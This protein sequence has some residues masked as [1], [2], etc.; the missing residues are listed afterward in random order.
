MRYLQLKS[1]LT[2][3]F[4]SMRAFLCI[5]SLFLLSNIATTAQTEKQYAIRTIAFYNVENLY[6]YE[7][8]PLTWDNDW[9]PNGKNNWTKENYKD[10]LSKLAKVISE[11]GSDVTGTTP[12]IIGLAE[13]ENRRVLEDLISQP[14]L[15]NHNYGIIHYDSPDRRGID[16]ALI[17]K[18][19]WF[20]P[21]FQKPYELI[22][23]NVLNLEKRKYTRDQLLVSGFLDNEEIH[24]IV[25][26]WPSRFGGAK[27]SQSSRAKAARLNRKIIDS[28]FSENPYAK[29]ITMG[30]F[31][32]N[33]TDESLHKVLNAKIDRKKLTMKGLYN[34]MGKMHKK[35]LPAPRWCRGPRRARSRIHN[36][37]HRPMRRIAPARTSR[38]RAHWSP[39]RRRRRPAPRRVHRCG[40]D[41]RGGRPRRT[42]SAPAGR[43]QGCRSPRLAAGVRTAPVQSCS[44]TSGIEAESAARQSSSRCA[45]AGSDSARIPAAIKPALAAPAAPMAMVA[46]G[47]PLGICTME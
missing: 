47:N 31:N 8:D 39:A 32:D 37:R 17:Y 38:H 26:H 11:I 46:T 15:A 30:D 25:N 9:T 34:P 5:I 18:K 29:I 2:K 6:D 10:K 14:E 41:S 16:V 7:D 40:S 23:Y 24:F 21:K 36:S 12:D 27:M 19:D 4:H 42:A 13:I 20:S 3:N 1:Y 28:I 45:S 43:R 35:G 33:P 44:G 22:L